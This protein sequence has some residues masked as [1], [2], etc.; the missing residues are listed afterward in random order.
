MHIDARN[1]PNHSLIEG[2]VCII[3]A[4][5]A[6]ISMALDWNKTGHKVILLEGGGFE[7][8]NQMQDLY[9]GENTG[10]PYYPL[11][12][13]RLHFFGG[14]TGHWSG[15]C[16]PFE[17]VDFKQREW[18]PHSGWP[19]TKKDLEPFYLRA[20]EKLKLGPYNYDMAFWQDKFPDLNPFPLDEKVVWNKMWQFNASR[21]GTLYRD[22]IIHSKNISLYTYAKVIDIQTNEEGTLT[23]ELLIKNHAGKEHRVR[24]KHFILAGG[25]IQNA[26]LL[27][28]SN[29]QAK[30]GLGNKN[31]L[32]GRYFMEHLEIDSAELWLFKDFPTDLYAYKG[33]PRAEL[34]ITEKTQEENKVL[35]GTLSLTPLSEAKYLISRMEL[36]KKDDYGKGVDQFVKNHQEAAEKAAK[37]TGDKPIRAFEFQIRTEQAPNPDSRVTLLPEKDALG[38]PK[39]NL[40]WKLT[41]LDKHSVRRITTIIGE[42]MGK[43]GLG[44]VQLREF[45][46][47]IND[48]TSWPKETNA[49]WHHMG[50]T[51]M[52]NDPKKGVVDEN[53]KVHGIENLYVAGSGC[54]PTSGAPNPTLTLVALS[55]RLSDFVKGK[56][57]VSC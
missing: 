14:T 21:F 35:N 8:E 4:G 3:G 42:E 43:A 31:D 11:I 45:L 19:L 6:G 37:E 12:G 54:F 40:H 53:C 36:L 46:H 56:V 32:V 5:A 16:A 9:Q 27:L 52:N 28:A 30:E 38:M 48:N 2:D 1:L 22:D 13:T 18:V 20:Q 23:R 25:A 15:F 47:D 39:V 55:L 10:Q 29:S 51:R 49:G 24:A 34:A 44:R 41:E 33:N 50:T 57:G 17:E 26:R 7:Y